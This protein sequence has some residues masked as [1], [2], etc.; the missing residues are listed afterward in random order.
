MYEIYAI[1]LYHHPHIVKAC[2]ECRIVKRCYFGS[3]KRFWYNLFA[4][5]VVV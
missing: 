3:K 4:H 2:F 5:D 1:V